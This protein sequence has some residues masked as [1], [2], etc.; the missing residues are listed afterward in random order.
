MDA[1]SGKYWGWCVSNAGRYP[2]AGHSNCDAAVLDMPK[3][4]PQVRPEDLH[5]TFQD[6]LIQV[7]GD[8]P[9]TGY[10]RSPWDNVGVQYGLK[11]LND[12]VITFDQFI[13]IN[14]RVGGLDIDGNLI[15]AAPGRRPSTRCVPPT[16][17]ARSTS[18]TAVTP[19][20]PILSTRYFLDD[21]PWARGDANVDVHDRYHSAITR[22][23]MD[24]YNGN[25]DNYVEMLTASIGPTYAPNPDGR[26]AVQHGGHGRGRRAGRV[27]DGDRQ[28]QV[29]QD[30]GA[31]SRGQQAEGPG[32]R[33]LDRRRQ[34]HSRTGASPRIRTARSR[35]SRTGTSATRCSRSTPIRVS[36]P[37]RR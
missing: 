10:G 23:R 5:C 7:F 21:D 15:A 29:Q 17:P 24:K 18:T 8:D 9:K 36:R 27:D 37:V 25:S 14:K 4:Y 33:L 32:E 2:A 16:P 28:R 22:A 20:I 12:G 31:E 1:V 19:S 26:H 13:D 11:A 30:A 35:R 3:K 34:D 6:D